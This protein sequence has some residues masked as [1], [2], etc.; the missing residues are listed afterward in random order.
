LESSVWS[1]RNPRVGC[2]DVTFVVYL[3]KNNEGIIAQGWYGM[4]SW[5]KKKKKK[6]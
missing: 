1:A 2:V 3:H 5:K 4:D 6:R